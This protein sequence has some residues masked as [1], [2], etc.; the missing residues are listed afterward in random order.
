VVAAHGIRAAAL[1]RPPRRLPSPR[2]PPLRG[3]SGSTLVELLAAI[4]VGLVLWGAIAVLPGVMGGG[5]ATTAR[6]SASIQD[7]RLAMARMTREVRQAR[8]ATL[9]SA[10]ELDV[11]T[12]VRPPGGSAAYATVRYVCQGGACRRSTLG[13]D[14]STWST[15][16]TLVEG[17]TS[18]GVFA[19]DEAH[20]V[21]MTL[22]LGVTD[23]PDLVVSG[24]VRLEN[25]GRSS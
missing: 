13:A 15:P 22:R 14:G 1:R 23:A 8:S 6:R 5:E 19:Q 4:S 11:Q 24:G 12:L 3:E 18:D 2:R 21:R 20:V 10:H 17:V 25:E 7:A 9:V 16:V